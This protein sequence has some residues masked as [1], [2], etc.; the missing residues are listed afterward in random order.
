[1]MNAIFK[2]PRLCQTAALAGLLA[3]GVAGG[4]FQIS[5]QQIAAVLVTALGVQALGAFMTATRFEARSAVITALLLSLFLRAEG[6]APLMV[7]AAIAIGSKFTMRLYGKHVFN[8]AAAG[9]VGMLIL[10]QTA[11]PGAA[12]TDYGFW[13][14]PAWLAVMLAGAGAFIAWRANR[15]DVPLIFLGSYAAL[16]FARALWIGEPLTVPTGHM[17]SGALLLFAFFMLPDPKTT[18]DGRHG[19]AFFAAGAAFA[20]YVLGFQFNIAGAVFYA[21]A[22]LCVLRPL[23]ETF[24]PAPAYRW[25]DPAAPLRLPKRVPTPRS[26]PAPA[27]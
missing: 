16:L 17:Q 26:H 3:W 15:L 18:P 7:A 23:I 21:L 19:R 1:M 9:V 20:A 14:T 6:F 4:V 11:M 10:S 5:P 24:D 27:E 25:G 8:P 2:D 13:E 22:I 12:W